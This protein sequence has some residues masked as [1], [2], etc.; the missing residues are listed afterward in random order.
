MKLIEA[1]RLKLEQ[2]QR[3]L[4][5]RVAASV[6]VVAMAMLTIGRAAWEGEAFT[7]K[8]TTLLQ[9]LQGD[10]SAVWATDLLDTGEAVIPTVG[11]VTLP[12][13]IASTLINPEGGIANPLELT[14]LLMGPETPEGYPDWLWSQPSVAWAMAAA[15]AG[16]GLVVVWTGL[17][18]L[19]VLLGAL[20]GALIAVSM[21]LG[22]DAGAM[23]I[24]SIAVLLLLFH[25]LSRLAVLGLEGLGRSGS[26]AATVLRES[27]RSRVALAFVVILLVLLP[28]LPLSLDAGA[29]LRHQVQ[30]LLDRSLSLSFAMIAVMTMA[31]GCS[32]IAFDIRDRHIWHLV[33]KPLGT[34]RYLLGK[35]MGVLALNAIL[36][37][38]SGTFI[39]AWTGYLRLSP[40]KDSMDAGR[41]ISVVTDEILTARAER[42]PTY[43]TM[44]EAQLRER[45][46]SILRDDPEYAHFTDTTAPPRLVR[47]LRSE[48]REEYHRSQRRV[49]TI[50]S[51]SENPWKTLH[52]T[53]LSEARNIGKPIRIRFRLIGGSSDEHQRRLVGIAINEDFES[54]LIGAFVPTLRQHVDV[55]ADAIREDGT[56]DV[57]FVNLTHWPVPAGPQWR[58]ANLRAIL[59]APPQRRPFAIFWEPSEVEVLYAA[60]GFVPNYI[61]ALLV[62]WVRLAALAAVACFT[63]TFLSFPVACLASITILIGAAM[64][65]FLGVALG[66]FTPPPLET[67]EGV[68]ATIAWVIDSVI[69]A[70]ASS[71]VY[72]LGSFGEFASIDR[73]IQGRLVSWGMVFRG[74]FEL[75]LSWCLPLLGVGWLVLRNRQLAIYS[76]DS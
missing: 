50:A 18:P 59:E 44:T 65:P 6:L 9:V 35:W 42:F 19:L 20:A 5:F 55:R 28:L 29:P 7:V 74:V 49:E 73:L 14:S 62:Q 8:F 2:L 22:W 56:I 76:G 69:R 16:A 43:P 51:P 10:E 64:G 30:A 66:F 61:R 32:T 21:A 47:A 75:G 46:D 70:I 33:T 48:V 60:G 38:V 12:V 72:L 52:F 24:G 41:D 37:V 40:P 71:L 3:L 53:G 57:S 58:Q 11:V 63:A 39:A 36:L 34:G 45:V 54:G 67:V 23:A 27:S 26:V 68:G 25:G 31:V 13:G 17:V 4:W 1:L 15:A